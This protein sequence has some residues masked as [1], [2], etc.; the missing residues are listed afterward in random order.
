MPTYLHPG[1]FIEEIP[2][3][4]KTI[5]GVST[6]I[7]AFVGPARKGP[8]GEAVLIHS[9]EDYIST[10]GGV[11]SAADAMGLSVTAYYQ[12]GGKDAYIARLVSTTSSAAASSLMLTGEGTGGVNV[13]KV[14]ATSVGLWGNDLRIR[15]VKPNTTDQTFTL[16]IG[17]EEN[18]K[19]VADETFPGLSMNSTSPDYALTRG[20][21]QE[22]E[23]SLVGPNGRDA[24]RWVR[25][26]G[27]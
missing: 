5:E 23:L 8:A 14:S 12:N 25:E 13:L 7:T 3:G 10:F 2:S 11:T 16:E 27:R 19:F 18:G 20:T 15:V 26:Q 4:S 6:S 9:L 17:H 22:P 21:P 1:V 24:A